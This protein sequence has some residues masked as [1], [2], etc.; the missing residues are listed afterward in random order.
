MA[1]NVSSIDGALVLASRTEVERGDW[2]Q[3]TRANFKIQAM[4][5]IAYKLARVACGL[6]DATWTLTPKAQWDV[7]GGVALVVASGGWAK[8]LDGES[9]RFNRASPALSGLLAAGPGLL[10]TLTPA[11]LRPEIRV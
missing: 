3:W 8:T 11:W 1:S 7:A 4:G 9:P 2:Q 5:S 10:R 6:A